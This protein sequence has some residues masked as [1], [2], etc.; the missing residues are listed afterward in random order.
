MSVR[1]EIR[2]ELCQ[3][4]KRCTVVAPAVFALGDD[5]KVTV[6]DPAGTTREVVLKAAK[7]CPYRVITVFDDAGG[8]Q[9]WP[10]VRPPAE[11]R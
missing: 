3:T 9:L 5:A 1:I 6:L 8:E 11:E 7:S 4:Y 2:R 10:I